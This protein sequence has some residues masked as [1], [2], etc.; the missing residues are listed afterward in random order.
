MMLEELRVLHLVPK[1]NRKRLASRHLEERPLK[2]NPHSETLPPAK[3]HL[4]IVAFPGPSIFKSPHIVKVFPPIMK[5]LC[6]YA[7]RNYAQ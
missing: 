3:P 6:V 1:T 5:S 4:L 2:A 7:S